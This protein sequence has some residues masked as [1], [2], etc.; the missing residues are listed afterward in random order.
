VVSS[1]GL[2]SAQN[3]ARET[4]V[5]IE[6][7]IVAAGLVVQTICGIASARKRY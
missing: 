7:I 2:W 3:S 4:M 1:R 6:I 5:L